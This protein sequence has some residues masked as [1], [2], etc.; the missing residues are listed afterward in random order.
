MAHIESLTIPAQHNIYN[1]YSERK[2]RID[3]AISEKG[4]NTETVIFIFVPG[5]GGHID[6]NI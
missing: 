3:F 6:S 2:L 4:T 5:F 1:Q